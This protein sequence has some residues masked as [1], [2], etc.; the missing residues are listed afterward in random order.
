[1][2][3]LQNQDQRFPILGLKTGSCGLVI[4]PTKLP[5]WFL[6]LHLKIKWAMVCRLRHKTDRRMKTTLDTR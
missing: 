2:V 5:R 3:W 6:G 4:W 1:M